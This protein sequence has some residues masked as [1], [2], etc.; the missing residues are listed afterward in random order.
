VVFSTDFWHLHLI[1]VTNASQTALPSLK[2]TI[3]KCFNDSKVFSNV[4]LSI[5]YIRQ[6]QILLQSAIVLYYNAKSGI[7]EHYTVEAVFLR[8]WYF[9]EL[10]CD[11]K[12]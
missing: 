3:Q 10:G 8:G 12:N 4:M 7:F 11:C 5:I 6:F 1:T 2:A 9:C